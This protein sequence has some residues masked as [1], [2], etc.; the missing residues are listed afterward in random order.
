M[1][2]LIVGEDVHAD[3]L[4][5]ALESNDVAIERFEAKAIPAGEGEEIGRIAAAMRTFEAL[6]SDTGPDALLL[7][8]ASNV[9]LAAL[10]VATKLEIPV[11]GTES[12]AAE[13]DRSSEINRRLIDRLADTTL[14]AEPEAIMAWLRAT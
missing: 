13:G 11:A 6:L 2:L 5:A 8:S 4:A 7:T 9:A 3:R 14:A 1:K 12:T 10:L